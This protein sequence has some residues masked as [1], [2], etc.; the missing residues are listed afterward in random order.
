[1]RFPNRSPSKTY[2]ISVSHPIYRTVSNPRAAEA[3]RA[4][5]GKRFARA[6]QVLETVCAGKIEI[7]QLSG[8]RADAGLRRQVRLS[9]VRLG[10][11]PPGGFSRPGT[12]PS[13]IGSPSKR[14]IAR[15][16]IEL[17]SLS[18]IGRTREMVNKAMV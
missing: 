3:C 15:A 8:R 16:Q 10:Q 9:H 5:C 1:V 12:S 7:L 6:D 11:M 13:W 14:K 17:A 4:T 2:P 18:R